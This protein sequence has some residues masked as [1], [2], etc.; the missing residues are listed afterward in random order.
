VK[1]LRF[2]LNPAL[3]GILIIFI[4]IAIYVLSSFSGIDRFWEKSTETRA[5]AVEK[6]IEK[7]AIQCYA[8]EGSYP[9]SLDYLE[10]HYGLLINNKKYIY[11]YEFM[12]SNI[13]PVVKVVQKS[14]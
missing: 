12:A 5:Q 7:A 9:I 10:D 14:Y 2:R 8:L 11:H 3:T 6:I 4:I 1:P 13:I